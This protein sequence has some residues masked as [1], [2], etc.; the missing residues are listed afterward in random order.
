MMYADTLSPVK[1]W[2]SN[3]PNQMWYT[4]TLCKL[5]DMD[6]AKALMNAQSAVAAS[7]LAISKAQEDLDAAKVLFTAN[8]QVVDSL[9]KSP[10]LSATC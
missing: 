4:Y 7:K 10:G 2:A 6:A 1:A 9:S 3:S 8:T 5:K